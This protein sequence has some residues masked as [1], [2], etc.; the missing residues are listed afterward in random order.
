[1]RIAEL[2]AVRG[3]A[4]MVVLLHHFW[5]AALPD[6]NTILLQRFP[7]AAA[8]V[9]SRVSYLI[10]I[11]PLRLLFSGH[12]AVGVFFVLSGF[13]LTMSLQ[14]ARRSGYLPFLVQRIFRI[15]PPFALVIL[16]AA[17]LC[18]LIRP[19]PI[20]GADWMNQFWLAPVTFKLVLGHLAMLQSA[21][22]YNSLNSLMWTL[23]HEMRIA[24]IFPPLLALALRYPRSVLASSILMFAVLSVTH[25]TNA[26]AATIHAG[27]ARE[28]L[29]SVIQTMRYVMFFAFGILL[30]TKQQHLKS[31]L[32]RHVWS[33]KY[34]WILALLL[35][36]VPYTAG[37]LE[38]CYAVGAFILLTL[39]LQSATARGILRQPMLQWLGQ[40][41]Y[42][43]YLVHMVI[44]I[45][46]IHL[47][48]DLLPVWIV[49]VL[50]FALSL[51]AAELLYQ[52]VEMPSNT[53]GKR[54]ATRLRGA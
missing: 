18:W 22:Y 21:G 11:S 32:A 51:L 28:A 50:V 9:A 45:A 4:A 35:L 52:A 46:A 48:R 15:Y 49:L 34:L 20:P 30:A 41:S 12:A 1:M 2:D 25:W 31:M 33:K 44:L 5:L 54:L 23:V 26:F 37:Y 43:L 29:L 40:V 39:C 7:I 3:L 19:Q 38:I 10:S 42:S 17:S 6:Q 27:W 47:L 8:G 36:I 14:N 53:I 13:A 16:I 24:L